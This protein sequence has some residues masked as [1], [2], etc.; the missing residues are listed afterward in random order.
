MASIIDGAFSTD[1]TNGW[2]I[3]LGLAAVPSFIQ[4]FGFLTMPESPRWLVAQG[5]YQDALE[6]LK[7][8]RGHVTIAE[9]ELD[10]IKANCLETERELVTTGSTPVFLQI[11]RNP[12]VKRAL[13]VGCLLQLIQQLTAINTGTCY[14]ATIIQESGVKDKTASVWISIGIA[15]LIFC[16]SFIGL[17]AVDKIGRRSL[18]LISL[19]GISLSLGTLAVGVQLANN[20]SPRT[21]VNSTKGPE[22]VCSLYSSCSQGVNN[23][24]CGYCFLDLSS[25]LSNGNCTSLEPEKSDISTMSQCNIT[26]LERPLI[27][28]YEWCYSDY[29]W[30]I[31]IG[32]SLYLMCF[33]SGMSS[34][35]WTVN[36]EIYPLW[37]RSTCYA[38]ATSVNWLSSLLVTMTFQWL[39]EV[40]TRYGTFWCHMSFAV[41]GWIYLFLML[42][43]TKGKPLEHVGDL[44]AHPWWQDATTADERKTVQYV[45]IRGINQAANVE[46]PDSGDES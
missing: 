40:L 17:F 44:F 34:M 9:E 26:M 23:P 3:M 33:A 45:H 10:T 1:E 42:P 30:L 24:Y 16:C 37:A 6:V 19:A 28:A 43:E 8:V 27:W 12:T 39:V 22:T 4:F 38:T 5:R 21:E 2:R 14:S 36:S 13:T 7:N 11:L 20:H 46:D 32:F 15:A 29:D 31:F 25:R 18:T 35:P 41:L